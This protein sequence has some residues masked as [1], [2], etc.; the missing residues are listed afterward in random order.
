MVF[1]KQSLQGYESNR[2]H[3]DGV[4]V[5]NIPRIT[6]LGLLEMIQSLMRDLQC[7]PEPFNDRII[8]MSM[9][10]DIA[11][12]EK[13]SK[14]RCEY[15]SQTVWNYARKY[16]LGHWSF[17]G[18]GSEEK[19][20]GTYTYKPDGSWDQTAQKMMANF[21]GSGHPIFHALSAFDRGEL[22]SKG[23]GARSQYN[24]LQ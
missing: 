21:S 18:P 23:R 15:N 12:Q 2:R 20:Y 16:P 14:E 10:N 1:G 11:W 22:R 4:R 8:F 24:T 6:T 17:L 7:E 5:E 13:G 19:W 9:Y 3:A